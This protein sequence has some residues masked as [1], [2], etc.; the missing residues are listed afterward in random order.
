MIKICDRGKGER[1]VIEEKVKGVCFA[2]H[3]TS[4]VA[5]LKLNYPRKSTPVS[6]FSQKREF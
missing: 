1:C 6:Y 4:S 3:G 2:K 5:E